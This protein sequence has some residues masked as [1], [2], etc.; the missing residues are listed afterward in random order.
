LVIRA[1]EKDYVIEAPVVLFDYPRH[2]QHK[3]I[4]GT[5]CAEREITQPALLARLAIGAN[6]LQAPAGEGKPTLQ[7]HVMF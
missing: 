4:K 5:N 2:V 1:V 6:S 3:D 7:A